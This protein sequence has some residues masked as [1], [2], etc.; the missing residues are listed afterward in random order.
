MGRGADGIL[1]V[2]GGVIG[3]S[4]LY[5]LARRGIRAVLVEAGAIGAGA[6]AAAAGSLLVRTADPRLAE[7]A[8]RSFGMFPGLAADVV[9]RG[10]VDTSY[11][12]VPRLDAAVDGEGEAELRAWLGR[13]APADLAPEWLGAVEAR[14]VE[15]LLGPRVSGALHV[16]RSAVA[17]GERLSA[18]L[19]AAAGAMG[20][21]VIDR[22]GP[23]RLELGVG[24]V[25]GARAADGSVFGTDTVVLAAG[26]RTATVARE[27]GIATGISPAKGQTLVVRLAE[28]TRLRA[29]V[30]GPG[31][32]L[33]PRPDGSV[34]AGYTIESAGYDEAPTEEA[35]RGILERTARV[36]PAITGA[37]VT[38]AL[39]GLRPESATALPVLGPVPGI[40]GLVIASGHYRV[41]IA[42]APLTGSLIAD[43]LAGGA[44]LPPD[45]LP[46]P[47][48]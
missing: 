1:I 30:Y 27:A 39:A 36:V 24:R 23:V 46:A 25:T 32:I 47:A 11:R 14:R 13:P 3:C 18:A 38:A 15:P 7:L 19:S 6:S 44:P 12:R 22:L 26:A 43:H 17:S 48:G 35:R 31:A 42:L 28:G 2:G 45:L 8:D 16:A 21:R 9:E 34:V 40:G 20:A 37:S 33:V 29:N 10:G 41:G 4:V 5:H